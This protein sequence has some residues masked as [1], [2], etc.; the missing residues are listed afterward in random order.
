[1]SGLT[2]LPIQR[3]GDTLQPNESQRAALDELKA[4]AAQAGENLHGACPTDLPSTPPGRMEAMEK[5]LAVMLQAVQTVRPKL[6]ALY[7]SLTDEQKAR[8]NAVA[9]V[10]GD[11]APAAEEQRDLARMCSARSDLFSVDRIAQAVQPGEAQRPALDALKAASGKAADSLRADCPTYQAL[12]ATGRVE[13]MEK[14]L[15]T[16]GEAVR[17][18]RPSL[19]NFWNGL[20]DE[21]KARFS[22]MNTVAQR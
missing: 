4:A 12:T 14:R 7:Q 1:L 19:E 3:I 9:Q 18:V 21:Q 17:T 8:F 6:D 11:A 15:T 10:K 5:R 13:A 22:R 16:V 2:D 20:S